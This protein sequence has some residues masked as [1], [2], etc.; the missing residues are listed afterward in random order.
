MMRVYARTRE[1]EKAYKLGGICL[2]GSLL[3]APFVMMIFD[4][5]KDWSFAE[6][7]LA[8]SHLKSPLT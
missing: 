8:G 4:K 5:K 1:K 3:L 2:V 6:V 7:R